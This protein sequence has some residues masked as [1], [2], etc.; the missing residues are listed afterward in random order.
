MN[1]QGADLVFML[2]V[3]VATY[4]YAAFIFSQRA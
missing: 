1:F 2:I 4:A 3:G